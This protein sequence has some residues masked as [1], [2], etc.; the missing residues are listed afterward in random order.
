MIPPIPT[1]F[2]IQLVGRTCTTV[3]VRP[4]TLAMSEHTVATTVPRPT[5]SCACAGKIKARGEAACISFLPFF[6]SF[7]PCLFICACFAGCRSTSNTY[8][9]FPIKTD[10]SYSTFFYVKRPSRQTTQLQYEHPI[11]SHRIARLDCLASPS[12][13]IPACLYTPSVI[14]ITRSITFRLLSYHSQSRYWP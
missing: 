11:A 7:F 10:R 5:T 14:G 3:Y 9:L 4:F 2:V 13:S 6:L 12:P 1:H 8:H